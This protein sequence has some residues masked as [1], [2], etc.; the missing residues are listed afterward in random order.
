MADASQTFYTDSRRYPSLPLPPPNTTTSCL[1]HTRRPRTAHPTRPPPPATDDPPSFRPHTR[2]G[3]RHRL[4]AGAAASR[5][6]GGQR[7]RGRNQG[8]CRPAA[9]AETVAGAAARAGGGGPGREWPRRGLRPRGR[10]RGR[11]RGRGRRRARGR[12]WGRRRGRGR[13]RARRWGRPQRRVRHD[14]HGVHDQTRQVRGVVR[15]TVGG[16]AGTLGHTHASVITHTRVHQRMVGNYTSSTS[17]SQLVHQEA[18]SSSPVR[19][20]YMNRLGRVSR[21]S[22]CFLLALKGLRSLA[23]K[24]PQKGAYTSSS[25]KSKSHQNGPRTHIP[26]KKLMV[27]QSI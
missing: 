17:F 27:N 20:K 13:R 18:F 19:K 6:S 26:K 5:G 23:E 4:Q 14:G 1:T 8:G 10:R 16:G 3:G 9:G 7:R 21:A 24:C 25:P 22:S 11:G 15:L 2:R 12:G